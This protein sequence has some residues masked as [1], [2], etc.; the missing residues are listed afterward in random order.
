MQE[1]SYLR[2]ACAARSKALILELRPRAGI[3]FAIVLVYVCIG[4]ARLVE[5]L[6][7]RIDYQLLDNSRLRIVREIGY[8]T[9]GE[10]DILAREGN[11]VVEL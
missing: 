2:L 9:V 7:S 4:T 1:F 5:L 10:C 3:V 8:L 6:G 11:T